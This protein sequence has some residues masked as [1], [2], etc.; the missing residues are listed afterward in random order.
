M[1]VHDALLLAGAGLGCLALL[2]MAA[3][4]AWL[5]RIRKEMQQ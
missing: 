5:A 2:G 4:G 3:A 1:T